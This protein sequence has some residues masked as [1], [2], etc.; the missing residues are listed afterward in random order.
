M[1]L[2]TK[3]PT[4]YHEEKRKILTDAL[5]SGELRAMPRRR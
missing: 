4:Q 1:A 2:S 3:E 5:T